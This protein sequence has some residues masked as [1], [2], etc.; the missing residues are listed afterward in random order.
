MNFKFLVLCI[1]KL[2]ILVNNKSKITI[3]YIELLSPYNINN[4]IIIDQNSFVPK[5]WSELD[6]TKRYK[7]I[8]HLGK[9]GYGEV[10]KY[11]SL[12]NDRKDFP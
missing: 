5:S 12:A 1:R 6:F 11:E 8:K 9:G 7:Y 3:K 10:L 2:Y 4:I